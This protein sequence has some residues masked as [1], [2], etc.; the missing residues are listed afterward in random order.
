[1]IIK[2]AHMVI[3]ESR[4]LIIQQVRRQITKERAGF[5]CSFGVQRHFH[6]EVIFVIWNKRDSIFDVFRVLQVI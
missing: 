6:L 2:Q 5:T 1:M 4:T 3:Y